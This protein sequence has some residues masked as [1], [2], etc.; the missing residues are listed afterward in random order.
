MNSRSSTTNVD[1]GSNEENKKIKTN[2]ENRTLHLHTKSL[3]IRKPEAYSSS[4][5]LL[6]VSVLILYY[7]SILRN[8]KYIISSG[9]FQGKWHYMRTKKLNRFGCGLCAIQEY[10]KE[11][12]SQNK[13]LHAEWIIICDHDVFIQMLLHILC[14]LSFFFSILLFCCCY[15]CCLVMYILIASLG[16]SYLEQKINSIWFF[17]FS[18]ALV[19]S[20]LSSTISYPLIQHFLHFI[21]HHSPA[22]NYHFCINT[23]LWRHLFY[24]FLSFHQMV[25]STCVFHFLFPLNWIFSARDDTVVLCS[26]LS[27]FGV[28]S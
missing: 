3:K 23:R 16:R 21:F 13:I 4:S 28:Y 11:S 7:L 9:I 8:R 17:L 19:L 20:C 24:N 12:R 22:R 26:K 6:F 10:W 25:H 15:C 27:H 14:F 5:E 18:F 2:L 1:G